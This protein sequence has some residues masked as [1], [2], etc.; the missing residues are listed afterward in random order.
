MPEPQQNSTQPQPASPT[1]SQG[2]SVPSSR[3]VSKLLV[4]FA[5]VLLVVISIGLVV[6]LS[7]D[8][9]STVGAGWYLFSFTMGLTMI[10]LP[11]TFPLAFVIV[12]L[13]MGKGVVKGFSI[14]LA[15]AAGI[16]ITLSL[17]GVLAAA[18]G[19]FAIQSL[20][21]D[22]EVVKNWMYLIAGIFAYIFAMGELGFIKAKMPTFSGAAP[23]F[24]QK[25]GPVFKALLLGLF[26][27]NIGV[28]CP[29]PA[30]PVIFTR[31]AVSGDVFY[32][33]LLFFVHA[34]GRVIPLLFLAL[35]GILGV[36][37]LRAL[38]KHREK[39]EKATGWGMVFVAGFILVLGLFTHDW[40]VNSGQHT[41]LEAITQEERI[42]NI[43]RGNLQSAVTHRHGLEEGTGL[44]GLPL[45]LGNWVLVLLWIIPLW[46]WYHKKKKVFCV[47]N[48][49]AAH[50][51]GVEDQR[52][53]PGIHVITKCE[54]DDEKLAKEEVM[55]ERRAMKSRFWGAAA[56]SALLIVVFVY[57]LPTRFLHQTTENDM[58][59]SHM[60]GS[61]SSPALLISLD[62]IASSLAPNQP[63]ELVFSL[64]D[65]SGNQ[66]EKLQLEHERYF[67]VIIVS[68]DFKEFWHGHPDDL[69]EL[70]ERD[71][72]A[73]KLAVPYTFLREGR[74]LVATSA[75]YKDSEVAQQFFVE[76]GERTAA[77]ITKN[78]SRT[79]GFG[80]YAATLR[81]DDPAI[82]SGEAITLKYFIER[83]G[84]PVR[85]L[86]GYLGAPMHLAMMSADQSY[87]LHTHGEVHDASG[88]EIHEITD[89]DRFGPSVEAHVVFPGPGLY[90]IFG[91]LKHEEAVIL[92]SFMVEVGQGVS[93]A[94]AT[95]A[96]GH[97]H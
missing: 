3:N 25:Q 44:F 62:T 93:G 8:S 69:S 28:G 74:Y 23:M 22:L 15:F 63:A 72:A 67:H 12:P 37:G 18:L 43:V 97:T 17:Y 86:R 19:D 20:G 60:D 56:F 31:I 5:G 27:G 50:A 42:L 21:A 11:C 89:K 87:F 46:V 34:V 81:T 29:H 26:L 59:D 78:L 54:F 95:P 61:A 94:P 57:W 88:V 1:A 4:L 73:G 53:F 38:T 90:Q 75:K 68:E 14:A 35:L 16:T 70:T 32:G 33:W 9:E 80:G 96:A 79:K 55:A 71:L 24:I 7:L 30:T 66:L 49:C 64:K 76:V 10:V 39:I 92:T 41:L 65:G 48:E 36:N 6:G 13:S 52:P 47:A 45:S 58:T 91:E 85:D 84:S 82:R 40:W 83:E 51:E 2:S 77:V